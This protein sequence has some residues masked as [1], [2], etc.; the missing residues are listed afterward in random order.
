M[1]VNQWLCFSCKFKLKV[2][3]THSCWL[4]RGAL[5]TKGYGQIRAQPGDGFKS[6]RLA[7]RVSYELFIGKIPEG[8]GVLHKCDVR[9]CV[10]PNHLWL[11]NAKDNSLDMMMKGR[12]VWHT[13]EKNKRSIL[14]ARQVRR[15]RERYASGRWSKPE[16]AKKYGVSNGAIYAII[17]G[18]TWRHLML[19]SKQ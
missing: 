17:D 12:G 14:T 15:I 11:G 18:K 7:H 3:K 16:L 8:M 5:D 10:N 2:K 1:G 13:G 4:W 9:N 6:M 19:P